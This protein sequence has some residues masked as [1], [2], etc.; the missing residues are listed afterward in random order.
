MTVD[1]KLYTIVIKLGMH[2][3]FRVQSI[4]AHTNLK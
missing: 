2:T 4:S 3:K 1:N